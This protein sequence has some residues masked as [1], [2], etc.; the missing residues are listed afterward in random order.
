MPSEPS[1][2]PLGKMIAPLYNARYRSK[3]LKSVLTQTF[4]DFER[5]IVHDGSTGSTLEL[6]WRLAVDARS[7]V[8]SAEWRARGSAQRIRHQLWLNPSSSATRTNSGATDLPR[9]IRVV[10]HELRQLD[11][12]LENLAR[13]GPGWQR[14]RA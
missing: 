2:S 4:S 3:R 7:R 6:A 8:V 9:S 5:V 13:R 14:E 10:M 11:E 12:R 1:A